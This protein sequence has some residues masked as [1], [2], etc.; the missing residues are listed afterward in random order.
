MRLTKQ[1]AYALRILLVCAES[2]E[3]LTKVSHIARNYRITEHNLF[4]TLPLLVRAGHI[5]SVRGPHGGICLARPPEEIRLGDILRAVEDPHVESE[6]GGAGPVE[7][8]IRSAVPIN[9]IL[10]DALEAFIDVLNEHSLADLK[11]RRHKI[12]LLSGAGPARPAT[13]KRGRRVQAA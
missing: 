13:G 9:R 6:C 3:S 11:S 4:K 5:Q 2:G 12:T 10:D 1:T 8:A 7:C